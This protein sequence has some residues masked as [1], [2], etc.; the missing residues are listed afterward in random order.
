MVTIQGQKQFV[1]WYAGRVVGFDHNLWNAMQRPSAI[2][3][4]REPNPVRSRLAASPEE[5]PWSSARARSHMKGVIPD[6][7]AISVAMPNPQYQRVW[8]V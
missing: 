7:G 1:F 6:K 5:W 4:N 8:G 2:Q 3:P